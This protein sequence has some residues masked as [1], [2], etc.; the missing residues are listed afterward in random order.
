MAK[1]Y[2]EFTGKVLKS[3]PNAEFQVQLQDNP[4]V[5]LAH[6]SGKMRMNYIRI[7]PGDIVRLEIS[8]YDKLKGRIVFREKNESRSI[9]KKNL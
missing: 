1:E 9:S 3:L 5:I 6:L 8:P 2:Y 4:V 7:L